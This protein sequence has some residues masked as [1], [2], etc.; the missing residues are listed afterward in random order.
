MIDL[1][2]FRLARRN[3]LRQPRR[4]AIALSSI[5]FGVL[6]LL[7]SCGFIEWIFWAMRDATIHSRLGHI[8]IARAGFFS[9]SNDDPS[10]FILPIDTS[11]LAQIATIPQVR[12]VTPRLAFSGL[13][14][15]GESTVSYIGEGVD[16]EM[17]QRVSRLLHIV[18]GQ[19]LSSSDPK[20]II[21]GQ[22]LAE[23]LG[24]NVGD[25]IVLLV[26]TPSGGIN[27]V[28]GKVRGL[29]YTVSK[30]FDDSALRAPIKLARE[31]LRVSGSHT[32]ILLLN[33]S[34][35]TEEVAGQLKRELSNGKY[36]LEIK[37]WNE[38]AD[39]Y[40]K[41]VTLYSRQ[42]NIVKLIIGLVIILSIANTMTMNVLER[43]GEIGTLMALGNKSKQILRLFITEGL[44]LG[45]IGGT[46]GTLIGIGLASA[47][48]YV[49]IPMP[50]APGMS[51]GFTGEIRVTSGLAAQ[52]F[53]LAILTAAIA[54]VY[55]AWK[56]SKL[57]IVDALRYN[58]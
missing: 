42:M 34:D 30:Q 4:T 55:P 17:E 58:R 16:P 35:E 38:L 25:P 43:T 39:F 48:S 9:G 26:N 10:S 56:A 44:L 11:E 2:E 18:K 41:T 54:S 29:F 1:L 36:S 31:L 19:G 51:T 50:P 7:L 8:Q 33:D 37:R 45:L 47:I 5:L 20:G 52:A 53:I 15:S 6:A 12:V 24:V 22:G 21:L 57:K 46:V 28:E 23:I 32:W 3:L 13:A 40:N 14:S 49:G 27:A